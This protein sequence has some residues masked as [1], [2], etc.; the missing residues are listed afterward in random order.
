MSTFGILIGTTGLT[1]ILVFVWMLS[2]SL[3]RK[4][5]EEERKQRESAYRKALEKNRKKEYED[6]ILKAEGG[7]IPTILYLAKEAER[8]NIKEALYWYDKA[9]ELD[10]VT[11]MYGI[12]RL[13]ERMREDIIL[14]EKARFWQLCINAHD[15]SAA[16]RYEVGLAYFHGHGTERNIVKAMNVIQSAAEENNIDAILFLGDWCASPENTD[17]QPEDSLYWFRKATGLNNNVGRMKVGLCYL[18]GIGIEPN[19]SKACYWLERAGEKGNIEAMYR[20]GE[21]WMDHGSNGNAIAYIWLLLSA[22][23]GYEPARALRDHVGSNL[24]VDSVVGL[25]ALAKPMIKKIGDRTVGKHAII[26]AMN[27]LYKRNV[28]IPTSGVAEDEIVDDATQLDIGQYAND[29]A[30]EVQKVETTDGL[31]KL[32]FSTT[33]MDKQ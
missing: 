21:A 17:R 9:A 11:G 28:Q 16:A 20:A 19:H 26:K 25:Q 12:V 23:F 27:K 31:E 10:S 24:G 15:G 33:S 32:D 13:S 1:L 18:H 2:L 7:H 5:L 14:K 4:R 29:P 3:R 30:M 22:H 8:K 6:R